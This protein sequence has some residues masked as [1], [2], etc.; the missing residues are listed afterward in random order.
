MSQTPAEAASGD[1]GPHQSYRSG[2]RWTLAGSVGVS[3]FQFLQM[4]LFARL[5]GPTA[6]GDYALAAAVTGFLTPVAEAGLSQAVV[7]ARDV[8]PGH[9]AALVWVN[10]AL[11][12]FI[13]VLIGV[14]GPAFAAWYDRPAVGGLLLLMGATLLITPFGAQHAGLLYRDLHFEKIARIETGSWAGSFLLVLVLCLTGWG[15]WAMAAGFALRNVLA[16]A[17]CL[18]MGRNLVPAGWMKTAAFREIKPYLQ[19]GMYDLGSRWTDFLSNY[20]DKLIVG[21]WLGATVLGYYNTAFTLLMLPTARLGYIITRVTFP[22]YARIREDRPQMQ[23]FFSKISRDVV[24]LLFP[25]YTGMMVFSKEITLL[26]FGEQWLPAAPLLVAFGLAGWVRT[27]SAPF[28]YL[29]KG[30]GK[31]QWM[32]IWS[33]VWTL[34]ANGFLV[35]FLWWQPDALSAAWSRTIAKYSVEIA[36]LWVLART[37]G[38]SFKPS[39]A[40]AGFVALWLSPVVLAVACI[41]LLPLDF[42]VLLALKSVVFA[43]GLA[44]VFFMSPLHR[45]W[46]LTATPSHHL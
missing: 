7:Q 35:G 9:V 40:F 14:F 18:W 2:I 36:L 29:L 25:V 1:P 39:V 27:L 16:T 4:A 31:P 19:F 17:G 45:Y 34:V 33:L 10:F 11:G 43:G 22:L 38:L 30:L 5:A 28:P 41:N 12:V 15:A 46:S 32:L 42:W 37:C 24:L 21:K 44:A 3:V 20:L 6:A 26:L 8:K 23:A 13:F